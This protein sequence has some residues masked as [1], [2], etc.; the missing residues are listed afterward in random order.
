MA[1]NNTNII[2]TIVTYYQLS[3]SLISLI[4]NLQKEKIEDI[5]WIKDKS[6]RPVFGSNMITDS[7]HVWFKTP[8]D[9]SSIIISAD[10]LEKKYNKNNNNNNDK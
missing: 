6:T 10:Y 3:L 1:R 8:H 5:K 7:W 2:D 9:I 4:T